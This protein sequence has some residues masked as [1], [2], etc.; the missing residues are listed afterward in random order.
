MN[1]VKDTHGVSFSRSSLSVHKVHSVVSIESM[2]NQ[3]HCTSL[4]DLLLLGVLVEH[5]R[6]S[7]LFRGFLGILQDY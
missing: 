5:P 1:L 7:K 2:E 3:R 6:E 4:E